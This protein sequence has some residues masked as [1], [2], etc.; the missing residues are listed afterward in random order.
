MPFARTGAGPGSDGE[1]D[2]AAVLNKALQG[3]SPFDTL[4]IFFNGK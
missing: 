2:L 3:S 4:A 1:P